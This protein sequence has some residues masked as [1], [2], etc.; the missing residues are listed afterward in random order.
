MC[1]HHEI[2]VMK[3]QMKTL[4]IA[5]VVLASVSTAQAAM[6][7]P[8]R[9]VFV[10]SFVAECLTKNTSGYSGQAALNYCNCGAQRMAS[11]VT[12]EQVMSGTARGILSTNQSSLVALCKAKYLR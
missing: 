2:S 4:L 5:T 10:R 11:L 7:K 12:H 9:D 6:K 1:E 3:S 8:Y